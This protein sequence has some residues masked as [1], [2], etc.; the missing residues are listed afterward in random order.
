MPAQ[1]TY[2]NAIATNQMKNCPITVEEVKRHFTIDG[3]DV[4]TLQA[5]TTKRSGTAA[6]STHPCELPPS[7]LEYHRNITLRVDFF[8]VQGILFFH[9]IST[10]L[11]F[12]TATQLDYRSK[13]LLLQ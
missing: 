2:E 9:S 12:R 8:Y 1:R 11:H 4:A 13:P 6:M 3:P 7:I 10:K 5:K